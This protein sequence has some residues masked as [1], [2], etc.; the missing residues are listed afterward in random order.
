[1]YKFIKCWREDLHKRALKI[2][3]DQSYANK[4]Y[5]SVVGKEKVEF[6]CQSIASKIPSL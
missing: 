5:Q 6:K 4:L 2:T 1:M 3:K